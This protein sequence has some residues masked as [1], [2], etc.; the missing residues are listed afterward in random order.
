M[1]KQ[2]GKPTLL[3]KPTKL[4]VG[5]NLVRCMRIFEP[6]NEGTV[7]E[8]AERIDGERSRELSHFL[9]GRWDALHAF[10]VEGETLN[11]IHDN[12]R[13]LYVERP[14]GEGVRY[15]P[16]KKG[17][18]GDSGTYYVKG[19]MLVPVKRKK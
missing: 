7:R 15:E 5:H 14:N 19:G 4:N 6:I 2:P 8:R 18:V 17:E 1:K 9:M 12:E 13:L 3:I 11:V 16:A 10:R